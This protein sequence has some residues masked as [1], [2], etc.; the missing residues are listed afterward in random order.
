MNL[1]IMQTKLHGM[2]D[3]AEL[4]QFATVLMKL[5]WHDPKGGG[6]KLVY[7]SEPHI[8]PYQAGRQECIAWLEGHAEA[9]GYVEDLVICVDT[10]SCMIVIP[11]DRFGEQL[12]KD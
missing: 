5:V 8:S 11:E 12:V 1:E 2:T 6:Y 10:R 7:A 4:K 9:N 3:P